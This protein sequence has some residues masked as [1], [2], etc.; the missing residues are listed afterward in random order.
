[1]WLVQLN[2]PPPLA[3]SIGTIYFPLSLPTCQKNINKFTQLILTLMR[4]RLNVSTTFLSYLFHIS[5][6]TASRV[7]QD[8]MYIRMKPLII[9]PERHVL[10]TT[11][12]MQ[13]R[14]HFGKKCVVI[15]DCFEIF[16]DRPSN[17]RARAATWSNYKHHNTVKF[18][19]WNYTTGHCFFYF[20]CMGRKGTDL[21]HQ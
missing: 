3:T 6:S 1:M 12:P 5:L 21:G 11:M 7:F 18:F 8:V 20:K 14:K 9:W 13:F 4:L 16:I 17:L 15:I 10:H 19:N 2:R